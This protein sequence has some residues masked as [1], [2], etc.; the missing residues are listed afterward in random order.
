MEQTMYNEDPPANIQEYREDEEEEIE[1]PPAS[2]P[3]V[4]STVQEDESGLIVCENCSRSFFPEK[5][6]VHQKLCKPGKPL[7]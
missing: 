5:L 1:V 6:K 4:E 3:H 2:Y 7:G